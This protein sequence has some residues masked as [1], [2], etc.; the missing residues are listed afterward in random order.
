MDF[1][2]KYDLHLKIF[3]I[4]ITIIQPFILLS[5][6]GIKESISSYW[7]TPLQPLFIFV[8][9]TTSYYL[10][11]IPKWRVS[12]VFLLLLTAF[13]VTQFKL[14][15]NIFA[16]TFFICCFISLLSVKRFRYYGLLYFLSIPLLFIF[17]FLWFEIFATI[18][19]VSYHFHTIIYK[20]Y[21]DMKREKSSQKK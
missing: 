1:I 5:T 21:L 19:I 14:I 10:F 7:E 8:N 13:S 4:I 2:K 12:S 17:N 3:V 11:S 20:Q 6:Q 9:A 15:H 18:I 16:L